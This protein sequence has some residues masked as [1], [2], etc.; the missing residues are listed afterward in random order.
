[1]QDDSLT[2]LIAD[3]SNTDR[4]LLDTF[5]RKL[6]HKTITAADGEE[7]IARFHE[8]PPD[9]ILLDALMPRMSGFEVAQQVRREAG[10]TFIPII[11]LTA[12]TEADSLAQCLEAGGDDF[13]T[14]PYNSVILKAKINAF[15]RMLR[16]HGTL[17]AQRDE[18]ARHNEYLLR[19]QDLAKRIFDKVARPGYFQASN[20]RFSMSPMAMFN[21]DILLVALQPSG[22]LLALLGDFTGHGLAAAVGAMPLAQTFYGMAEKG[23]AL[24]DIVRELNAKLYDVLPTG[25]FC[26]ACVIELDFDHHTLQAWN[27][28]LPDVFLLRQRN[29]QP[30]RIASSSLPLGVSG[31][32]HFDPTTHIYEMEPGDRVFLRS[33]GIHET[34]NAAGEMFGEER[35]EAIF[36]RQMPLEA[37]FDCVLQ[38]VNA[39]GGEGERTDDMSLVELEMVDQLDFQ[40]GSDTVPAIRELQGPVDWV[41][42]YELKLDSIRSFNPLPLMLHILL[43]VP[44]LRGHAGDIYTILSELYAN[45]VEHGV[46]GLDSSMKET[47]EGFVEYYVLKEQRLKALSS[48]SVRF[49][50]EYCGDDNGGRLRVV[51]EDSGPGFA[52][53]PNLDMPQSSG[54]FSGRGLPLLQRLCHSLTVLPPGNRVEAV[55]DWRYKSKKARK[56]LHE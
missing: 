10:D 15:R 12:L 5:V 36:H 24:K 54:Q 30:E 48:A 32:E 31:N 46:A 40:T 11:F 19:E 23:F 16:M 51:V 45:A 20:L 4:L 1:M 25:I 6:G 42:D 43:E 52:E 55:Y 37:V 21:G 3:D 47:H 50:I 34:A 17:H 33:D 49:H 7:A 22:N 39:F 8:A 13:L 53:V 26:C 35:L 14:K 38:E 56:P 2:I 18:I 41:L 9:I 27:G 44:G 29:H 28:G